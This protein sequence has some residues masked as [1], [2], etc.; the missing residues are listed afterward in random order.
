ME[1][2]FGHYRLDL[3]IGSGGMGEVYRAFDLRRDRIVAL[4]LLPDMASGDREFQERF[5]RES[6]VVA[7]L[8]DPH[9]IP[10]HDYGEID[11]RLYLDMR[12][13]DGGSVAS[14]LRDEGG[15]PIERAV[16]IVSQVAEALDAAH[17][18]AL[19]HRDIKPSNILLTPNDFAY[20]VDFGI[21]HAI[22][23]TASSLTM[24]GAMVGT[25]D[26][27]APERFGRG[28]VDRRV[29]VYSLGC[30]LY[31][32]L[33]ASK[34]F[35]GTDLPALMYAHLHTPPPSV[36]AGAPA[37]PAALDAVIAAAMAK[38]PEDRYPTAG[39]LAAAARSA[40]GAHRSDPPVDSDPAERDGP[41]AHDQPVAASTVV[42]AG[43]PRPTTPEAIT[44]VAA[45]PSRP[46]RRAVLVAAGLVLLLLAGLVLAV[47][48]MAP[49]V[50]APA[51]PTP[52]AA[53]VSRASVAKPSVLGS[54]PVGRTPG[55][56]AVS[57]DGRLAYV[58]NR[59][60]R[61]V[62]I[63]D[64]ATGR[65]SATIPVPQGPPRFL[66]L[67]P[68]GRTA[69][70]SIYD[71]RD[72]VNLVAVLDTVDHRIVRTL[73]VDKRPFALALSPD[74]RTLWVPS[75]DTATIDVVD[76]ASGAVVKRVPVAPNPHW[77]AFGGGRA[78]VADHE[79]DLVTVLDQA[80]ASVLSTIHVGASPHSVVVSPDGRQVSVVNYD[81]DTVS[82][83]DP[84]TDRV[85]ATIPVGHNPQEIVYAPDGRHAYTADVGGGTVSVIDTVREVV[86]S[87]VR[88]GHSPTSVAVLPD[89][90]RAYVSCLDDGTLRVL[91]T[92]V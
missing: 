76:L 11:G 60:S 71:D 46:G 16:G 31:E 56:A 73:P 4:K 35:A 41:P 64:T 22:G 70:L 88:V 57:P 37:V 84:L 67:A 45:P 15:M 43:P 38:A 29:D 87:T 8:R 40:I 10:I 86:T 74:G 48:G 82:V 18:D 62:T 50:P 61:V 39:A 55:Y 6:A 23:Q 92:G 77:V 91:A 24:S 7:R 28:P 79:T 85:R 9:I 17:Q 26:Y 81:A 14:S 1:G 89:G 90:S 78:Y 69:Y 42:P 2:E 25:L 63:V 12:L 5:R 19:I 49:G 30:V 72:T 47:R 3:L 53:P 27:M 68:D 21:A 34:P 58:T 20:V 65:V 44:A 36:G 80:T 32:C 52:R 51:A 13:V 59:D 33:T 54:V 83:I 66:A 75:H